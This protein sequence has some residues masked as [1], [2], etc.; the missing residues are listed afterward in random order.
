VGHLKEI[1]MEKTRRHFTPQ[2]KVAILREHLIEHV[3][4]SEVFVKRL[5]PLP[6]ART[7]SQACVG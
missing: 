3:P 5:L 4:V 1:P 6:N 2:Q 7:A